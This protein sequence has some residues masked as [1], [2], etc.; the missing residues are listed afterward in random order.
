MKR[1]YTRIFI[2]LLFLTAN[3]SAQDFMGY[4][5]SNYSGI[6]GA[7]LNPASTADSRFR[8]DAELFGYDMNLKNNYYG[9]SSTVFRHTKDFSDPNFNSKYLF[10]PTNGDTKYVFVGASIHLPSFMI[11]LN[12]KNSI[13]FT[14]RVR[15]Y[16]NI[17]G[18][19]PALAR[20]FAKGL[21]DTADAFQILDNK[22]L[23]VE[24]MAWTEYG[25]TFSH[26]MMN[27]GKH[28]LKAGATAKLLQ[29]LGAA[30]LNLR[31][32]HYHVTGKDT[33]AYVSATAGVGYSSNFSSAPHAVNKAGSFF[34]F[35]ADLGVIYEYRPDYDKFKYDMDG[36]T[37]LD[38]RWKNK[39]KFK[40]GLSLLDVGRINYSR[41]A[42]SRNYT[43]DINIWSIAKTQ[44][45]NINAL[46]SLLTAKAAALRNPVSG[47]FFMNLP[48]TIS[49]QADYQIHNDFYAGLLANYAFQFKNAVNAIHEVSK[50]AVV[51]RWDHKWFGVFIPVSYDGYKN[52]NYGINLRLGHVIFGT[53]TMNSFLEAGHMYNAEFHVLVKVPI[54]YKKVKDRDKDKVS[55]KK[56]KCPDSPGT[57]E[58]KG[59]PDRDGDH[60]PD[61]EDEC[62]DQAGTKEF[63]GCPDRDGDGIIDKLDSCPDVKGP[64]Q[65]HGC[66]DRDGDGVIDKDD[67]CPDEAGLPKYKGCPD[68]DGDGVIDKIDLCP[69]KAGPADN[70]GCPVVKLMVLDANHNVVRTAKQRHDGTFNFENLS[71][72]PNT[73]YSLEG[74]DTDSMKVLHLVIDGKAKTVFRSASTREFMLLP[75]DP[76]K[77]SVMEEVDVPI[78]LTKIEEQILKKAFSNL[79]FESG[80]DI[81]LSASFSSLDELEKMMKKKP[82]WKLKLSGYTDNS[83]KKEDNMKLSEKRARAVATYMI[84]KGIDANRFKVLWFGPENPIAPNT[85]PAGRQKNRRVEML[86]ID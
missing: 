2:F 60:I 1:I 46:D 76:S 79:E 61:N 48:T 22:N 75:N 35:G 81:I 73:L 86:I 54:P 40:F 16:T 49:L 47:S 26:V 9:I 19:E 59:C 10:E 14:C 36:E 74:D 50:I 37:N 55:D 82:E 32:L 70:E 53:N 25:L 41:S 68:R 4:S 72:D 11:R 18:L 39:Y 7:F 83:G 62:P 38:M 52:F 33:N 5:M 63:K 6:T 27:K 65:Y 71:S 30:Y 29:G 24:A 13:G 51:P 34:G 58:F 42:D 56:D 12:P 44:P 85:T 3:A 84:G 43:G 67:E 57:W 78:K 77:L 21:K 31:D 45:K 17:D 8:F 20:Q 15:S 80:K 69:D 23:N 66:P 28:F 64:A